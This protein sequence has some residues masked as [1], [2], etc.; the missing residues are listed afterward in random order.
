MA[1]Q[2][3]VSVLEKKGCEEMEERHESTRYISTGGT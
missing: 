2:F 3:S 1:V